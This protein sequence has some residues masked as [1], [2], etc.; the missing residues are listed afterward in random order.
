MILCLI[1]YIIFSLEYNA[2]SI[3]YYVFY[4]ANIP[5]IIG[6]T[7]P[8]LSHFWSLGV[9]EQFYMFWPWINKLRKNNILLIVIG[10]I[11]LLILVKIYIHIFYP[12]STIGLA[13]NV[14]RFQCMLIGALGAIL[15][16]NDYKYFIKITT[17]KP[18]QIV[19]WAIMILMTINKYHIAS[20]LDHEIL[21]LIT[22]LLIIGQI[23][24][25]GLIDLENFILDFLGKISYG[26]YVI[27]PLLI[28]LCSKV[29]VEVTSYSMLNY[30]IVYVSII[31]LTIVLSYFS[32]KYLEMPFLRLKTKKYT[33]I[34]SSGTR[35][36]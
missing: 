12:D 3:Y 23:T 10:L 36:S 11:T 28:F 14:T 20:I 30:L 27:H 15:Y 31:S 5:F 16:K 6:G 22:V 35:I 32:Y 33:V 18:V 26:M 7:L 24:K 8:F 21:T 4:G 9:E 13:I 17:S 25:K 29:L 2:S 34:N 1:T 19:S